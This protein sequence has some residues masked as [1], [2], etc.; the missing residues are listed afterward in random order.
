LLTSPPSVTEIEIYYL[1]SVSKRE[2]EKYSADSEI[3][4]E[5]EEQMRG[6]LLRPTAPSFEA[7]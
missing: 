5:A 2:N 3:L 7:S 4:G 6:K 1:L